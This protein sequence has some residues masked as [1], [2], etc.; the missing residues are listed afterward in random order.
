MSELMT[1]K[2]G[3][4]PLKKLSKDSPLR[5]L[6]KIFRTNTV[7]KHHF[8]S[9]RS[10]KPIGVAKAFF[11]SGYNFQSSV[12]P[13]YGDYDR[14]AR[15]C[16]SGDTLIA[17]TNKEGCLKLSEIVEKF[18]AGED[19]HVFS[20]DKEAKEL[21]VAPISKAW[22]TKTDKI[23]EVELDDGSIVQCTKEHPFMLKNGSYKMA[24]D[25]E[26]NDALMVFQRSVL[27][28]YRNQKNKYR[29]IHIPGRGWIG[30]HKLVAEMKRGK[31]ILPEEDLHVHHVDFDGLNNLPENLEI[32]TREDHLAYH[33]QHN[34]HMSEVMKMRWSDGGD[35]FERKEEILANL[36]PP[37]NS[38]GM[39][40]IK[41]D[42]LGARDNKNRLGFKNSNS[43]E[44]FEIKNIINNWKPGI[45]AYEL[46]EKCGVHYGKFSARIKW[47]G[48]ENYRDFVEKTF[49]Y[50]PQ[51]NH[52]ARPSRNQLP[53]L[54]EV[55]NVLDLHGEI[56]QNKVSKILEVS[57]GFLLKLIK[58]TGFNKWKEFIVIYKEE[59]EFLDNLLNE[60]WNKKITIQEIYNSY[61]KGDSKKS[62]AQKLNT[63]PAFIDNILFDNGHKSWRD[64][65]VNYYNHKVVS[66]KETDRLEDVYDLTVPGHNNFMIMDK[67]CKSMIVVH[68][69][70]YAEMESYPI[71]NKALDI[72]SDE[73]TQKDEDGRIIRV[74]SENKE[75][76]EILTGLFEDVLHLNGKDIYKLSRSLCKYGDVFYVIDATEDHG[77]INLINMPA[78]EVEREE[79]FDKEEPTAVRFKWNRMGSN[80]LPN[81]YVAHFRLDGNDLFKPYGQC[82]HVGTCILTKD[83]IKEAK[84][85]KKGDYVLSFNVEEQKQE[86]S[87]VLDT[88]NSGKKLCYKIKTRHNVIEASKEHKILIYRDNEF[89][90]V[91]TLDLKIGD[92]LTISKEHNTE[93]QVKIDKNKPLSNKNGYWKNLDCIPDYV[94]KEFARLFGFMLGDGWITGS[95]RVSLAWGEDDKLNYFYKELLEKFSGKEAR[96]EYRSHK[97]GITNPGSIASVGSGSKML[98][99]I[100]Q[101]M[102]FEGSVYTKRIPN[103]VFSASKEIRE[104]VLQ[105]MQDADGSEFTDKWCTRY[106]IELANEELIKDFKTL[107]QSL[108]YKSNN[109]SKRN[110]GFGD[111]I[112]GV[113]VKSRRDCFYFYFY[114]KP[115]NQYKSQDIEDRKTN[116]FI[117]EPIVSIEKSGV[118]ETCDIYV[119][120][121]D[122][123]FYANGIVV[124]NSYLEAARRPWRQLVLM[125][126]AMMV[127]RITR[128]P[129]RRVYYLDIM[130]IPPDDIDGIVA[131]F[132]QTIK[133]EKVVNEQGKIDLRYGSTMSMEEDYVIPVR[134]QESGTR[135]DTLPG[136]QNASDIEDIE[137]IKKNLFASLGIPKAFLTFDED[138]GAKVA[139]T[140]EDIRFSRTVSRIQE[141]IINELLKIAIIHLYLKGIRGKDLVNFEI[142]MTNPSTVAE[143]QK[144]ELWRARMELVQQAG[145]GVFDTTFIYKNF[146]HLTDETIDMIRKGQIMD[147]MFQSKLMQLEG[148]T[149]MPGD[150][151]GM[152]ITAG[153]RG[154]GMGGMGMGG[155]G[156]GGLGGVGGPVDMGMGGGMGGTAPPP[157]PMEGFNPAA[158]GGDRS[159]ERTD[160]VGSNQDLSRG[161]HSDGKNERT[162]KA[163]GLDELPDAGIVKRKDVID[164]TTDVGVSDIRAVGIDE[165]MRQLQPYL[166]EYRKLSSVCRDDML[167]KILYKSY[168]T[169]R[170]AHRKASNCNSVT[171]FCLTEAFGGSITESGIVLKENVSTRTFLLEGIRE[172]LM[173]E[174][175]SSEILEESMNSAEKRTEEIIKRIYTKT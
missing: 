64:F 118:H 96:F 128:A 158:A 99:T 62:I 56:S 90:Y 7:V 27:E 102:G 126:D 134:G 97:E 125:E 146:L 63:Y 89:K 55:V 51:I 171:G 22:K 95:N 53:D 157:L 138:A 69:S 14:F 23:W 165:S 113:E 43:D 42:Q 163:R 154:V 153:P 98:S 136:G 86:F 112:E 19:I 52:K 149:G 169:T 151:G 91:S 139:L 28:K 37:L 2:G 8:Q 9:P 71:L 58:I 16:L 25:L 60:W 35:L 124:H 74:I 50:K 143:L 68:N 36:F 161:R 79:G 155:M 131:K 26:E 129:E 24:Q 87:K 109:I 39:N 72:L 59:R 107:V 29:V 81:A 31:K 122:H 46:A 18:E 65:V 104:E 84:D 67:S 140:Q 137:F 88:I 145:E 166:S 83:G 141:A 49:D 6:I 34:E 94:N 117:L 110:R 47:S 121:K 101:R 116:E 100:L 45:S 10:E 152:G 150:M 172:Q 108:G 78:N 123:N 76:E 80:E 30:E 66:V 93:N 85:I 148:G 5:R 127:Y 115:N 173:Q 38:E 174:I 13:G 159:G 73:I 106:Q 41:Q 70:D 54:R 17:T 75:I 44:G 133:K 82:L 114:K 4:S 32:M 164:T 12:I 20:C 92:K 170:P 132:N 105:G 33:N 48:F 135:I 162:K 11:K 57:P 130:G 21:V 175:D 156:M 119:D 142:K 147:K 1:P 40:R 120:H 3:P 103:W 15:Y 144:N 111:I 168:P 77:V 61:D 160:L 167:N